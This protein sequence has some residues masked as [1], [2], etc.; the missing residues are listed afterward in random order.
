ME[1]AAERKQQGQDCFSWKHFGI[2]SNFWTSTRR[3]PIVKRESVFKDPKIT[4]PFIHYLTQ[5][6]VD[7]YLLGD[8]Q[9]SGEAETTKAD[10][11]H[12]IQ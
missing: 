1:W 5:W 10:L 11:D 8:M 4:P 2:W 6:C 9:S 7:E 3:Y 12:W